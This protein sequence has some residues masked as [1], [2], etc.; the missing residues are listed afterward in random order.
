MGSKG[1]KPSRKGARKS[2]DDTNPPE[3]PGTLPDILPPPEEWPD[4]LSADQ[5]AFL[6]LFVAIGN[7]QVACKQLAI[8]RS[9]VYRWKQTS[10]FAEA[11]ERANEFA[12]E[13]LEGEAYRRAALGLRRLKFHEGQAI[14]DPDTG[15]PY[16]ERV[17]SDL[18]LIVLLKARSAKYRDG[19]DRIG[20]A[21]EYRDYLVI[22]PREG[23][24]PDKPTLPV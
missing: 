8:C 17:Y 10:P 12:L 24:A 6:S 21:V 23:D 7:I 16:E 11:F 14:I 19:H 18:M 5:K 20:E 1:K 13:N 15:E 3:S 9:M 4:E 2:R 22:P